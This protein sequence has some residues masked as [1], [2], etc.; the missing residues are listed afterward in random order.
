MNL[1]SQDIFSLSTIDFAKRILGC[2][3]I[4][5]NKEISLGGIITEVEAYTEEDPACHAYLGK[6]TKRNA[7]MFA[8]AGTI[9]MYMI[10]GM[11]YCLNIV[12]EEEGRG[13]AVLIRSIDPKYNIEIMQEN[14]KLSSSKNISNGPGKLVQALSIP[15]SLNGQ[16]FNESSL[17]ILDAGGDV[18]EIESSSRIGIAKG[19]ELPW[20]FVCRL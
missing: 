4:Y 9:Y 13:C 14:R 8:K 15:M 18:K 17:K 6:K 20:R 11:Y 12:T 7:P 1:L 10:Y 19:K 3:L 16:M 5:E 2:S